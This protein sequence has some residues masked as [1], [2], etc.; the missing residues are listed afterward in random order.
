M[1]NTN[2]CHLIFLK[3]IR[4]I[5]KDVSKSAVKNHPLNAFLTSIKL[6]MK[7]LIR[8]RDNFLLN[9]SL[10]LKLQRCL[11]QFPPLVPGGLGFGVRI[12]LFISEL[13]AKSKHYELY[14]HYFKSLT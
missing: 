5:Y 2:I 6:N 13:D 3:L 7:V 12:D 14:G 11:C 4:F 10:G 8:D 9:L 1:A